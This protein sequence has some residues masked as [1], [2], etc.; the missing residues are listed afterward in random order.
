MMKKYSVQE[1]QVSYKGKLPATDLQITGSSKAAEILQQVWDQHTMTIQ[2][3]F[4]V[5]LLNNANQVKGVYRLSTGGIT[6]TMVDIRLLFAV[7]LKSIS[8]SIIVAHNHPSG[9][10]QPS[11]PDRQITQ[12][13]KKAAEY[14]DIHLLDHIIL[15]PFAEYYSFADHGIL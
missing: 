7:V 9:K 5:L 3:S 14:L 11:T 2:E 4:V 1:I 13:I 8:T 15:S 10:M 12:K 6:A